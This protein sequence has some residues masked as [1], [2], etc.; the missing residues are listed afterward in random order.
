MTRPRKPRKFA[1]SGNQMI[2]TMAKQRG[3]ATSREL[4]ERWIRQ[5]RGGKVD[6]AISKLVKDGKLK[7]TKLGRRRGSRYTLP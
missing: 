1:V 4:K 5:G 2:L 3:G 7:T 6:N